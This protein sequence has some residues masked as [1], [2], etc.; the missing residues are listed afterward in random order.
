MQ[1]HA[2]FIQA[3]IVGEDDTDPLR[4]EEAAD[5]TYDTSEFVPWLRPLIRNSFETREPL[6]V[7]WIIECSKCGIL[8]GGI[9]IFT[10]VEPYEVPSDERI[11]KLTKGFASRSIQLLRAGEPTIT[12]HVHLERKAGPL[13]RFFSRLGI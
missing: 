11:M 6:E 10:P 8:N 7:R 2:R 3:K 5:G 4:V 12:L 1:E 13:E 9:H